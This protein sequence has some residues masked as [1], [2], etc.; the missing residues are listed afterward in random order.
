MGF[1]MFGFLKKFFNDEDGAVTVDWVVLTAAAVTFGVIA[2][3]TIQGG[4][5]NLTG[6]TATYLNQQDL[7]SVSNLQ[8]V[9]GGGGAPPPPANN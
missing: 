9:Y 2:V 7:S 1:E 5:D 8:D 3:S 6:E 4:T